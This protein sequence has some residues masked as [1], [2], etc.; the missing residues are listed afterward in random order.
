MPSPLPRSCNAFGRWCPAAPWS[1]LVVLWLGW[2]FTACGSSVQ[3]LCSLSLTGALPPPQHREPSGERAPSPAEPHAKTHLRYNAFHGRV[4]C[5]SCSVRSSA[6]PSKAHLHQHT[7]PAPFPPAGEWACLAQPDPRGGGR[8]R[9]L[10]GSPPCAVGTGAAVLPVRVPTG[11]D[12]T[13]RPLPTDCA[14]GSA[15]NGATLAVCWGL[16]CS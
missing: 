2:G 7:P 12:G 13:L 11:A 14:Q 8:R 9:S 16:L 6:S 1:C 10:A 3:Q 4:C 5:K 15:R